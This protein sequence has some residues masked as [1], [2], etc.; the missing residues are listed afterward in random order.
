MRSL[1]LT[2]EKKNYASDGGG[3]LYSV[4][5]VSVLGGLPGLQI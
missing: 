2:C 4:I 3:I 5:N 1:V